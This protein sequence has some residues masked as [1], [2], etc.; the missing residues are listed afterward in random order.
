[1]TMAIIPQA[2]TNLGKEES[3]KFVDTVEIYINGELVE[4]GHNLLYGAGANHTRALL[5][6]T[7][8]G[9]AINISL[10]NSTWHAVTTSGC[11]NPVAAGTELF[12]NYSG[13][14]ELGAGNC[15]LSGVSGT[16][17]RNIKNP[18]N[19]SVWFKFVPNCTISTNATRLTLDNG[20]IF[21][22]YAFTEKTLDAGDSITIN[23]TRTVS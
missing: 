21:A 23:W 14:S 22:G 19:S 12:Q 18:G 9:A 5:D 16:V 17:N 20:T 2:P 4:T 6:G 8:T 10:C 1:M 13:I 11:A 3:L 7:S 15:N